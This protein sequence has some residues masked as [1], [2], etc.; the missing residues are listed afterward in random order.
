MSEFVLVL[1]NRDKFKCIVELFTTQETKDNTRNYV[2]NYYV[3]VFL[4]S[5]IF[6]FAYNM[7]RME[8]YFFLK[9]AKDCC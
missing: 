7:E 9:N 1:C 5:V 4:T 2:T 3:L 6:F 8:Y